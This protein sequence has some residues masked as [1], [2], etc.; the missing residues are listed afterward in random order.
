MNFLPPDQMPVYLKR[1]LQ[2][3]P[4]DSMALTVLTATLPP[5]DAIEYLRTGLAVRPIRVDWHRTYQHLTEVSDPARDLAPEYRKLVDES[6]RAPDAVYLLARLGQGPE[7]DKLYEEAATG[8][9]P[10]AAACAGLSFRYLVRGE[11]GKAVVWGKKADELSPND[12]VSR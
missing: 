6:K 1:I 2:L 10:S 3:D 11:F 9:P 12:P 4:N 8:K 5:A 7:S